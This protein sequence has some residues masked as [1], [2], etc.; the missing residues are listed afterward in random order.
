M[1]QNT[2]VK[3]RIF[4]AQTKET[5]PYA[6]VVFKDANKKIVKGEVTDGEGRFSLSILPGKYTMSVEF[7]SYTDHNQSID[8]PKQTVLNIPNIFLKSSNEVLDAIE[9]TEEKNQMA[10]KIDKREFNVG[11]DVT[12][13]GGTASQVLEN[14]PSVDVDVE[15]N[16]SLRGSENVR[17]LINGR[18]SS[19]MGISSK[20]A[21]ESIPAQNI[22]KVEVVTNPS[23]RYDADGE[24]G[25]INIILKKEKAKGING[26]I[27][28]NLGTPLAYGIGANINYRKNK[29]NLFGGL[30]YGQRARVGNA[31]INFHRFSDKYNYHVNTK[32]DDDNKSRNV[33][34]RL[35]ADYQINDRNSIGISSVLSSGEGDD[36]NEREVIDINGYTNETKSITNRVLNDLEDQ[37]GMDVT[38]TYDY[39]G[40]KKGEKLTGQLQFSKEFEDE[41]GIINQS[42]LNFPAQNK[43]QQQQRAIN[44]E[45][46]ENFLAQLDYVLPV[47][48][49]AKVELGAKLTTNNIDVNYKVEERDFDNNT[50][51]IIQGFNDEL[52]YREKVYAAYAI[53]ADQL[54]GNLK[55]FSYQLGLRMEHSDVESHFKLTKKEY[56]RTYTNFF[57]SAH[58]TYKQS[59]VTSY[60]VSYSK[61]INRP[62]A[63]NLMPFFSY[64][65]ER[66]FFAGNPE[67]NPSYIESFEVSNLNFWNKGSFLASVYHRY[68]TDVI[69]RIILPTDPALNTPQETSIIPFN[70]GTQRNTG[71]ELTGS[72][73]PSKKLKLRASANLFHSTIDGSYNDKARNIVMDLSTD[74]FVWQGRLNATY[75]LP[76]K[77]IS[78]ATLG[79]RSGRQDTQGDVQGVYALDLGFSKDVLKDKGTLSLSVRD[80]FNSRRRQATSRGVD[81]ETNYDFQWNS[82]MIRLNFTYR[83]NQK[84]NRRNQGMQQYQGG[85]G[86]GF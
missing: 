10:L 37:L 79:Y 7:L 69:D 73:N 32:S 24:A 68:T 30:S 47:L 81:F 1:A 8:I 43:I 66:N 62:R 19:L 83:I 80:V 28:A 27:N 78:Q 20:N 5:I 25:I 75:I 16:I 72:Y 61:R 22:E 84:K 74:N 45:N 86:G 9:L 44:D 36:T 23:A 65:S 59:D 31:E 54:A 26:V 17:V 40:K 67:L 64:A 50:W 55:K 56:P 51:D 42:V 34:F 85:G 2:L 4:D 70:I 53:Y 71:L 13:R 52:E 38:M 46:Q 49:E 33:M 39:K 11:K 15:G 76:Y 3:G 60:Q 12:N 41:N 57:P 35:G 6:S 82:R 21:L 29:W 63:W 77:I 14:I 48:T 18:P 58:I